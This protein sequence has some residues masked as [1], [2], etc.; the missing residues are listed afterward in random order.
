VDSQFY[1]VWNPAHGLPRVRHNEEH[2]ARAEAE[3]LAGANPGQTFY[4]ML[5]VSASASNAVHTRRLH[6]PRPV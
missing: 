5:A 1:V 3:R 2:E 4:V 6:E